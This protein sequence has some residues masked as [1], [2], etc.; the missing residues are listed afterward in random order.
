MGK[1]TKRIIA[2]V[3]KVILDR[4]DRINTL[5][6]V[7][8]KFFFFNRSENECFAW[9]ACPEHYGKEILKNI[10]NTAI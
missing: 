6:L 4:V 7:I 10:G 5:F 1:N 9:T 3:Q 2:I 8:E